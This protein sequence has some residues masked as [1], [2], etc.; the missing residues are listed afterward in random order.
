VTCDSSHKAARQQDFSPPRKSPLALKRNSSI[1]FDT[2]T[3]HIT[4]APGTSAYENLPDEDDYSEDE[5]DFSDLQEQYEV[6]LEE[7][8]DTFV[9]IDG[10]PKVPED[11]K[12][13]LIK[14]LLRKLNSVAKARED[15]VYMPLG[16]DGLSEGYAQFPGRNRSHLLTNT[17]SPSSS[18]TP[19]KALQPQ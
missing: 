14:F 15:S 6:R 19:P 1:K 7:G 10:L 5:I 4:M 8:L 18:L 3:I 16:K 9:V 12:P 2:A 13:K 17:D 11:S